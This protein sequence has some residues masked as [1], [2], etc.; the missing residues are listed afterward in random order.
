MSGEKG[1]G[2]ESREGTEE[3]RISLSFMS[4]AAVEEWIKYPSSLP[5]S[6]SHSENGKRV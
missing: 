4:N 3:Y 5:A 6:K 2:E 1:R